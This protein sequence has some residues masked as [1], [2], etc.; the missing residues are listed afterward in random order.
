MTQTLL[1]DSTWPE[2]LARLPASLDLEAS[3]RRCGAL[4]RRREVRDAASLLRLAFGY[5]ICGLS[6]RGAAAWAEF[7]AVAQLSNVALLKRLRGA[8]NW[9]GEIVSAILSDRLARS[10]GA[11]RPP[12][13]AGR[14]LLADATT[15]SEPGSRKTD[16]RVHVGYRLGAKPS[17]EQLELSD[18][19]GSESLS[20]FVCGAG[21]IVIGDRGYAK[22]GDLARVRACG[23]DFVVRTGWNATRLRTRSGARFD[24]FAVLA[25]LPERGVAEFEVAIA[26][27][28]AEKQLLPARLVVLCKSEDEATRSQRH[29]RSQSRRHGKTTQSQTLKAAGYVLL[30]TSLA[31]DDWPVRKVLELYR[32]R[33]QIELAFKRLKSLVHL[34]DLPAKDPDLARCW[35]YAKLIAAL[36]LEDLTG[37]FDDSPPCAGRRHRIANRLDMAYPAAA[38]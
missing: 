26:V 32:L 27:D 10:R 33:W 16:W 4:R 31:A 6:L 34:D 8:A 11:A 20:R 24:L 1:I 19:G 28:R 25:P 15:L 30:L 36:L 18:G 14:V 37:L 5:S 3:A 2:L 13:G 21:D 29:A 17:I 38:V 23:A 22:A 7:G 12:W 35:I 9:L